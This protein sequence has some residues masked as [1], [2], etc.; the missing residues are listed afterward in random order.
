MDIE[1]LLNQLSPESWTTQSLHPSQST[2]Q[3]MSNKQYKAIHSSTRW[4][5]KCVKKWISRSTKLLTEKERKLKLPVALKLK[6]SE[7]RTSVATS[8]TCRVW[9][10]ETLISWESRIIPVLLDKS[11]SCCTKDILRL[12][13]LRKVSKHSKLKLS[14]KG[15]SVKLKSR[16]ARKQL[17]S[18][19]K[20]CLSWE[21]SSIWRKSWSLRHL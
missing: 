14:K 19:R 7:A 6:E 3:S 2:E 4:C 18:R 13:M 1:L 10:L 20:Q 16:R 21:K 8:L 11:Y 17:K 15:K 9:H 5:F 12:N